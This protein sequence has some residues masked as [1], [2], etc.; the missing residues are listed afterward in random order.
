MARLHWLMT[1]A[2]MLRAV[3]HAVLRAPAVPV[4]V[5]LIDVDEQA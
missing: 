2:A 1:G 4:R 3:P 5:I